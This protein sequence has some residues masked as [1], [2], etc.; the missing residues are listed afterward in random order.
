MIEAGNQAVLKS[1]RKSRVRDRN[2]KPIERDQVACLL[3]SSLD[4]A[5][6]LHFYPT[7]FDHK[8]LEHF[9]GFFIAKYSKTTWMT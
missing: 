1:G 5:F 4:D 7:F 9:V 8:V 2:R 6:C 3:F